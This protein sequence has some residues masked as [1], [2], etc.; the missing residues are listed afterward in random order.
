MIRIFITVIVVLM[1]FAP[2]P[3]HAAMGLDVIATFC[4]DKE[5]RNFGKEGRQPNGR[6][7]DP[8]VMALAPGRYTTD[9]ESVVELTKDGIFILIPSKRLSIF[10]T[11]GDDIMMG[12]RVA[13]CSREQL[14]EALRRNQIAAPVGKPEKIEVLKK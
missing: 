3:S 4:G 10:G 13:G 7:A 6:E 1:A 5:G 11:E 9:D 14:S 2:A 12:K 8:A